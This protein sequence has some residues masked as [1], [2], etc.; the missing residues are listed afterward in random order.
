MSFNN[1]DFYRNIPK[2][3][4][5]TTSHGAVLSVCATLFMITLFVLELWAFLAPAITTDVIIDPSTESLL[6]INFNITALDVSPPTI[7]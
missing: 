2:D 7:R 5:E 6:R 4:T 1:F 3:L